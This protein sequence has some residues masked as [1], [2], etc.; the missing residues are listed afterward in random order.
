MA[1]QNKKSEFDLDK[2]YEF[3]LIEL[4]DIYQPKEKG[5]PN[6]SMRNG[7]P[8]MYILANSGNAID[9]DTG[10]IRAWRLITGQPSIWVDEQEGLE[11]ID[12]KQLSSVMA[13]E[14][15]QIIFT[16]GKLIVRGIDE[17]KCKALHIM[18]EFQDVEKSG[19]QAKRKNALYRLNKIEEIVENTVKAQ[20][21]LIEALTMAKNA[22]EDDMLSFAFASGIDISDTSVSGLLKIRMGFNAKAQENPAHFIKRFKDTMAKIKYTWFAAFKND[23]LSY[24]QK[25]NTLTWAEGAVAIMEVNSAGDVAQQLTD[26]VMAKDKETLKVFDAVTSLLQPATA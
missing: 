16:K 13:Q 20:E 21:L 17:L 15:N 9:P 7:Y 5:H 22:S 19:R 3:E 11:K 14:E 10:R 23:I 2:T 26:K 4:H 18:D 1:K 12:P 6:V 24:S 25:E 8:P